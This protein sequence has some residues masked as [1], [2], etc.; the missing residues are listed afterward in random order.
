MKNGITDLERKV[1]VIARNTQSV[2]KFKTKKELTDNIA[3]NPDEYV[4]VNYA[5]RLEFLEKNGYTPTRANF[6][7]PNLSSKPKK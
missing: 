7:N 4:P 5:D 6:I 2:T 1:G 3:I